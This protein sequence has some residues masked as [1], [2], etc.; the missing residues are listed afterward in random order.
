MTTV[1]RDVG[2]YESNCLSYLN[3]KGEATNFSASIM[4]NLL[5]ALKEPIKYLLIKQKKEVK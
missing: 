3:R 2:G 5:I 4:K 1:S